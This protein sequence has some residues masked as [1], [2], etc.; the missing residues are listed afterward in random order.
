MN[1]TKDTGTIKFWG[2]DGYGFVIDDHSQRDIFLHV[3]ELKKIG[4]RELEKGQR[5]A[6]DTD[7]RNGKLVAIN[8]TVD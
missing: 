2:A 7:T 1:T 5:I 6:Y 4:L 3:S 8:I